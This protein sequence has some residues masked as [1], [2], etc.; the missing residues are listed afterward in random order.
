MKQA[1]TL[2]YPGVVYFIFCRKVCPTC[3][4]KIKI[5]LLI[6]NSKYKLRSNMELFN[7]NII[8]WNMVGYLL[9]LSLLIKMYKLETNVLSGDHTSQMKIECSEKRIYTTAMSTTKFTTFKLSFAFF[10]QVRN[11]FRRLIALLS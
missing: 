2:Q 4:I 11:H 7:F 6:F 1:L 3:K 8:D 10:F 5:K 9:M